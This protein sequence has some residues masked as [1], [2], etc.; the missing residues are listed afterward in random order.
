MTF[1]DW[2]KLGYRLLL[3]MYNGETFP[4]LITEMINLCRLSIILVSHGEICFETVGYYAIDVE[5][6]SSCLDTQ[7]RSAS[8]N[9]SQ[10]VLKM[11]TQI[12]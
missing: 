11:V 2:D 4:S 12:K 10:A 8:I 6:N 9:P 1:S 7:I 3:S 5:H